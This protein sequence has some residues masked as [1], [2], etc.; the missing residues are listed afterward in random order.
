MVKI[1]SRGIEWCAD[2]IANFLSAMGFV[3]FIGAFIL[4]FGYELIHDIGAWL[5]RQQ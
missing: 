5:S 1:I 3:L 4:I 2:R